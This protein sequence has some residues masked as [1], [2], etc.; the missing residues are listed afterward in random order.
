MAVAPDSPEAPA[1]PSPDTEGDAAVSALSASG[2]LLPVDA[3]TEDACPESE[4][5]TPAWAGEEGEGRLPESA[6][7]S[8]F[9][10]GGS[11]ELCIS[12]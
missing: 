8:A 10:E 11:V 5:A 12:A 3:E 1:A 6:C 7:A 9:P 2:A 4:A